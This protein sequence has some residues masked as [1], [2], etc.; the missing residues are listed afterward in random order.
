MLSLICVAGKAEAILAA[1]V[2]DTEAEPAWA[3][4]VAAVLAVNSAWSALFDLSSAP[5]SA[6]TVF[7]PLG[8]FIA[9]LT[10]ST[11]ATT[12]AQAG[13]ASV[14]QKPA[15]TIASAF[16]ATQIS[17]VV[18]LKRIKTDLHDQHNVQVI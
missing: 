2:C 17:W 3:A 7:K 18:F 13:S 1:G 12:T 11:A 9:E 15:A 8:V 5:R 4:V 6:I 14:S 16:P 10:A